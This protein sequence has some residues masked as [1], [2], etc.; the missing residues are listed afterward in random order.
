M[1]YLLPYHKDELRINI[2][3]VE[4]HQKRRQTWFPTY[5][6][7][8]F[9]LRKVWPIAVRSLILKPCGLEVWSQSSSPRVCITLVPSKVA[10]PEQFDHC[11]ARLRFVRIER[12]MV[13]HHKLTS[14]Q[15][16]GLALFKIFSSSC[17]LKVGNALR[18]ALALKTLLIK[19]FLL[20]SFPI[21]GTILA[22]RSSN[23]SRRRNS[24]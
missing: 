14:S 5:L 1:T 9:W 21:A 19:S 12:N 24:E 6:C 3:S 2:N 4:R 13:V 8:D 10:L 18:M 7:G 16:S 11:L 23:A 22:S 20:L 15:V 17:R